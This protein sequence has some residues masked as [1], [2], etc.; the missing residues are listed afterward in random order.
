MLLIAKKEGKEGT[1]HRH[2][3]QY[4]LKTHLSKDDDDELNGFVPYVAKTEKHGQM[5][6]YQS[7]KCVVANLYLLSF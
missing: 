1:N 6:K 7:K 5:P 2:F 4:L 3:I